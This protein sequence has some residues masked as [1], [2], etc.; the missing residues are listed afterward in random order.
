MNKKTL[1]WSSLFGLFLW[2]VILGCCCA[3]CHAEEEERDCEFDLLKGV[4]YS[5]YVLDTGLTFGLMQCPDLFVETNP[6]WQPVIHN[7]GLTLAIDYGVLICSNMLLDKLYD[8]NKPVS[9]A[10]V[11]VLVITEVLVVKNQWELC[12]K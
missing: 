2:C 4:F 11:V 8:W 9:Y 6:F 7:P 1:F 10:V 3:V 5:S 12:V